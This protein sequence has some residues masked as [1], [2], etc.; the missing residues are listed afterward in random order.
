MQQTH[1]LH[2]ITIGVALMKPRGP[3]NSWF[4]KFS[5]QRRKTLTHFPSLPPTLPISHS[6]SYHSPPTHSTPPILSHLLPEVSF[7][8]NILFVF[9]SCAK[10]FY[11]ESLYLCFLCL[12]IRVY[13]RL[14]IQQ[15]THS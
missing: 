1:Y 3:P 14:C 2:A 4:S 13:V 8:L 9:V 15:Q 5:W 11:V 6:P 10:L 7:R 12:F